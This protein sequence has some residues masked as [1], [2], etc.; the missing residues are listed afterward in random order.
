MKFWAKNKKNQIDYQSSKGHI[1]FVGDITAGT[2][3]YLTRFISPNGAVLNLKVKTEN[4]T[5]NTGATTSDHSSWV[6]AGSCVIGVVAYVTTTITGATA[7]MSLGTSGS[8]TL[9]CNAKA[10]K[11]ATGTTMNS[12]TEGAATGPLISAS[13]A[14]LRFTS[15]SGNFSAGAVR[16]TMFYYDLTVPTS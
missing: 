1:D 7:N 6:P 2:A 14:T 4:L 8:A 10:S 11:L 5:L 9:W 16:V 13:A 15:S 12:F 3:G